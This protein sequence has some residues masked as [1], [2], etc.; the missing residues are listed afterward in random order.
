MLAVATRFGRDPEKDAL[1]EPRESVLGG[2]WC[3]Y[4]TDRLPDA[5]TF[6]VHFLYVDDRS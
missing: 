6:Y 1:L 3:Q 2:R 4:S 5:C